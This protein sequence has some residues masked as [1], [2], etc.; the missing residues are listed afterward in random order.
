MYE[1][2]SSPAMSSGGSG[3]GYQEANDQSTRQV[4]QRQHH[5]QEQHQ[6]WQHTGSTSEQVSAH[7]FLSIDYSSDSC[8]N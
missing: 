8:C 5:Q 4:Y 1:T 7:V 2:H 3:Y 6:Q